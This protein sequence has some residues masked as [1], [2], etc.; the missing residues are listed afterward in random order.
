M[1]IIKATIVSIV[2]VLILASRDVPAQHS[3]NMFPALGL[4]EVR[5]V[6]VSWDRFYDSKG[7][8][9][10]LRK[11]SRAYPQLTKL[12]SIGESYEGR[13]IWCLEVTNRQKGDPS[14]KAGMYIDGNIHGNEVQ[15]G[16]VVA[17]TAWYLCENYNRVE[18]VTELVDE[19]VFYLIPSINPDGRDHWIHQANTPHSSRSGTK[20]L[21]NDR[22]G[23]FDEDDYDD[24]NE[25]GSITQMRIRDPHG[26][27]KP[28]PNYPNFLMVRV[29]PEE[30]G[31]YSLLGNEGID[32]DG[33]GRINEDGKGGY[34][35]NRNWAY[36]WQPNYVQYGSHEYP[37]SLPNTRA[38][39]QFVIDHPNIAGGQ[40]YH[41]AGGMI[42]RGPGRRGGAMT[43]QDDRVMAEI[44][45]RGERMLPFYRSLVCWS[46]LYSV[47]GGEFDWFYG[48]RG[49]YTYTNELW[50]SQNMFRNA[51]H[52]DSDQP[53]RGVNDADFLRYLLL[54]EGMVEWQ[55]FNHPTYGEIEIGGHVKNF[56]RVPPSFLLQEECHRNMAYTLYHADMMPML[57]FG[58]ITVDNLGGDLNRI[59]VEI[60][61]TRLTPTRSRQDVNHSISRPDVVSLE[62]DGI[63]VISSGRVTDRY[64]KRVDPVKVRPHRVEIPTIWG[65]DAERI[66][67][68]VKGQGE[69]KLAVNSVKGGLLNKIVRLD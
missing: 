47:W 5:K 31:E 69:A 16:E 39:S 65:M 33:D 43:S 10:I 63:E 52:P 38:V 54:E 64:F 60:K 61:N 55:P 40:S 30:Q 20:P 6:D 8:A 18:K 11:L 41:N 2:I 14:R 45:N 62:G 59:W 68:I 9:E 19:R 48:A 49:I 57:E 27:W 42:L 21:D 37:F 35:S 58:D 12:Y 23:Q 46:G 7:L 53:Q 32:N 66:Q 44:A 26:R 36:D 28:H 29:E 25:D 3:D 24:L 34:D 50:N 13:P 67:F 51:T 1:Y 22:D 56:G 4:P 15:A 17:Y